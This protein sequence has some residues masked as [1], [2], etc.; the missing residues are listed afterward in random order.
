MQQKKTANGRRTIAQ[1][2]KEKE[3]RALMSDMSILGKFDT[4]CWK[5]LGKMPYGEPVSALVQRYVDAGWTVE[6]AND[7]D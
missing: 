6:E 4:G 3:R 5:K 7:D 2:V 1:L